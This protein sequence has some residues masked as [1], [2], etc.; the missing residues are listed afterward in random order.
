MRPARGR[1]ARLG[2][3]LGV[4]EVRITSKGSDALGAHATVTDSIPPRNG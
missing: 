4:A 3:R 2:S 1:V